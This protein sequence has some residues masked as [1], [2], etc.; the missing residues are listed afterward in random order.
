MANEVT[1]TVADIRPLKGAI[2]IRAKATEALAFGDAVYI[3][4]ATGD[5]PNVSKADAGA[6]DIN[7]LAVGIVVSASPDYPGAT[8]VA[9]GDPCDVVVVGPV[10][11]YL[12][13]TPGTTAWL[14]DTAGRLSSVV[15]TKSM[16]MGFV[17]SASTVFV[18]PGFY[19]R[20]S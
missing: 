4:T 8:T 10:T 2:S 11:G 16:V 20:A 6:V 5:I 7:Y 1:V 14:S 12:G 17:M 9:A 15:G 18:L 13:M 19:A 3:D